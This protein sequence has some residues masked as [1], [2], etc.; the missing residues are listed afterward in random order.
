MKEEQ[1]R[2]LLKEFDY[3]KNTLEDTLNFL[4]YMTNKLIKIYERKE[5]EKN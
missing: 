2:L 5:N 3:D 4:V 1:I